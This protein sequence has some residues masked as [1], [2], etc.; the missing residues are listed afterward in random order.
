MNHLAQFTCTA[1]L[2]AKVIRTV[3]PVASSALGNGNY[4]TAQSSFSYSTCDSCP[5]P[6]VSLLCLSILQ[7]LQTETAREAKNSSVDRYWDETSYGVE[8][9]A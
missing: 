9:A 4:A 8:E 2:V 6:S 3:L 7:Q 1:S 5:L